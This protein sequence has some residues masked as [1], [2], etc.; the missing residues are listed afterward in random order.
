MAQNVQRESTPALL[1]G[2]RNLSISGTTL[3]LQMFT[4]EKTQNIIHAELKS[5]VSHGTMRRQDLIP[6]LME[7]IRKTPENDYVP[8]GYYFGAHSGG[9]SDY[10][11]WKITD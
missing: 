7:I 10:G 11:F 6:L 3:L 8:E 5:S 9:K 4:N 1:M 2:H